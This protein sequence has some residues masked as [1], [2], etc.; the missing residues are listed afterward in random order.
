M[1]S[2]SSFL[3]AMTGQIIAFLLSISLM[4]T[5]VEKRHRCLFYYCS[6]MIVIE[7]SGYLELALGKTNNHTLFTFANFVFYLFYFHFVL[8]YIAETKY[9]IFMQVLR[10]IYIAFSL[11]NIL[12][13]QQLREL[14]TFSN[15]VGCIFISIGCCLYYAEFI[16][17]NEVVSFVQRPEFFLI[18]GLFFYNA[19][20]GINFT[21]HRYY[22]YRSMNIIMQVRPMHQAIKMIANYSMYSLMSIYCI[23]IWNKK[24]SLA[25]SSR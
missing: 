8:Q 22:A 2:L 11:I 15:I 7:V 5:G 16:A 6:F 19:L 3:F 9:R 1:I 13:I 4:F 21:I 18:T 23:L 10:I 25:Y 24:K 17:E 14:N 12:F 20:M